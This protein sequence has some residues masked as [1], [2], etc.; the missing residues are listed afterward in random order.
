MSDSQSKS[1]SL[2]SMEEL[3]SS[4]NIDEAVK[5]VLNEDSGIA[6]MNKE[7]ENNNE[8]ESQLKNKNE[9]EQQEEEYI[10]ETPSSDDNK[11]SE[12]NAS[13]AP[14][15]SQH[16]SSS[17]LP[18]TFK[19]QTRKL[20][21]F[22]Q[23]LKQSPNRK[24]SL[25][26]KWNNNTQ[27]QTQS[28]ES[29]EH[30]DGLLI[31]IQAQKM[32]IKPF[33]NVQM[34][35]SELWNDMLLPSTSFSKPF[36]TC[37]DE[38]IG[39]LNVEILTIMGLGKFSSRK[40]NPCVY[41]CTPYCAF[42]SDVIPQVK[43]PI[44]PSDSKRAV[45]FPIYKGYEKLYIGVFHIL[46]D[47]DEFCGRVRIGIGTLL[48]HKVYDHVYSLKES[49]SVYDSK[50]RGVVRL[51][52]S[53]EWKEERNVVCSYLPTK[54]D[55]M[56]LWSDPE[57]IEYTSTIP[58]AD[59]TFRNLIYTI[60]GQD[61]PSKFSRK[62]FRATTREMG[63]YKVHLRHVVTSTV[64]D[65]MLYRKPLLSLYTFTAWMLLVYYS[66]MNCVPS[67]IVSIV[68]FIFIENYIEMEKE[69]QDKEGRN[70][71]QI[72]FKDIASMLVYGTRH[73]KEEAR[74]SLRGGEKDSK[75]AKEADSNTTSIMFADLNSYKQYMS[76]CRQPKDHHQEF[77]F[78]NANFH[79]QGSM[80][81]CMVTTPTGK[82]MNM[83]IV[84]YDLANASIHSEDEVVEKEE[85]ISVNAPEI[86]NDRPCGP[87]QN[88]EVDTKEGHLFR[89][90]FEEL[91]SKLHKVTGN[92][93]HK[94]IARELNVENAK[95]LKNMPEAPAKFSNPLA[96]LTQTFLEPVMK[97]IEVYL[98]SIRSGFNA[99]TWKDPI[100][101]F[102]VL[103]FLILTC[104]TLIVFPWRLFFFLIGF[105]GFGPQNLFVGYLSEKRAKS[106]LSAKSFELDKENGEAKVNNKTKEVEPEASTDPS[107]LF[108]GPSTVKHGKRSDHG[109]LY[110]VIVP[111]NRLDSE[112]FYHNPY[113]LPQVET[114]TATTTMEPKSS[115][116]QMS[117]GKAKKD[118]NV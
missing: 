12:P 9:K 105:I 65:I 8:D 49:T 46:E 18:S 62:A 52:Y 28:I 78:S 26:K 100:L 111:C 3:L 89:K 72:G 113:P 92:A 32:R 16:Q 31:Q 22:F 70:T 45:R 39:Y 84:N 38:P 25:L 34:T 37:T 95:P 23:D 58:C 66:L 56:G 14:V 42:V 27:K 64:T 77:P 55:I 118:K 74:A 103:I 50:P 115:D 30:E 59:A 6:L 61:L 99:F 114:V 43:S 35:E 108:S 71:D 13:L 110:E 91:E 67:F 116:A 21:S 68:I 53:V 36:T 19:D 60:Y 96:A 79:R 101:S 94:Y 48:P 7:D 10:K 57:D 40:P 85:E 24:Q 106:S 104:F 87:E 112:R 80:G 88:D 76:Q 11:G 20:T 97:A 54:M 83:G 98:Y 33:L 4:E 90:N 47:K 63:L 73:T 29:I 102:W 81:D 51:R 2:D 75:V 1:S 107:L 93:F 41:V 44:F 117:S 109:K 17:P 69:Q 86:V 82:R 5:E 15:P